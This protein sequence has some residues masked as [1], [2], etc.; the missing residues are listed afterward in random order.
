MEW[1][2]RKIP[3][4]FAEKLGLDSIEIERAHQV[5]LNNRGSNTNNNNSNTNRPQTIIV[6]LL[7]FKD[8][9][10]FNKTYYKNIPKCQQTERA[11]YIYKQWFQ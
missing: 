4:Y 10:Y 11:K 3:G 2:Q 9:T 5:K 1:L 8:K 7:Q 6:K